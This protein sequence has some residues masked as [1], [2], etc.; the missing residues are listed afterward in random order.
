MPRLAHHVFF[1]LADPSQSRVDELLAD[2]REYLTGHEGVVDFS[3]GLRDTGLDRPVN[4]TEFH[5]SLHVVFTDRA[6]HDVYQTA[7][8][9]L[10]FISRQKGNWKS[11]RVCDSLLED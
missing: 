9:H 7:P 11:V 10:E 5:V 6:A 2:C 1:T 8:R 3:V 4:D